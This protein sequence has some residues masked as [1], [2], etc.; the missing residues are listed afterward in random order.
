MIFFYDTIKL[1]AE[2]KR[3][4]KFVF[5]YNPAENEVKRLYIF[6]GRNEGIDVCVRH[7]SATIKVQ[8]EIIL[9]KSVVG[10]YCQL[11]LERYSGGSQYI[12]E[13][14]ASVK[15]FMN[16]ARIGVALSK[17][18]DKNNLWKEVKD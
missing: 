16:T 8:E 17:Y 11:Y 1:M 13:D 6:N 9:G 7:L 5:V 4:Y 10:T 18:L 15:K 14:V 3:L 12:R 2:P